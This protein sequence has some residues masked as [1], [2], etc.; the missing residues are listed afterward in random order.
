MAQEIEKKF[1]VAGE[2]KESAKKA[3]RITQGYLSSVPERT[4]RVRVKGEKGYITVK[5]IGND[6]GASRFEWEKEI[7]VEDVRDLLKICEPGVIDKTRYLVDC[8]GHTFEVDEFYGDNE[9]LVVAEVEL[10]DEN[11]AFTRPS[12]LGE[13]VTGDKK[14]YNSMLMKNPYKNWK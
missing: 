11:E 5:G 7:P 9:G 12:W 6:S 14:Y 3:T 2:F 10:S 4:V 1:L 13:E 8:D